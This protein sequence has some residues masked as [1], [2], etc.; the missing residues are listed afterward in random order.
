MFPAL[1]H[2]RLPRGDLMSL[3]TLLQ[4]RRIGTLVWASFFC[5]AFLLPGSSYGQGQMEET[6]L[7]GHVFNLRTGIPLKNAVVEVILFGPIRRDSDFRRFYRLTND[8]GFWEISLDPSDPT[9]YFV[10]LIPMC[11]T[12]KGLAP[13]HEQRVSLR[14][15]TM[16]RYLYVDAFRTRYASS[17][18][19]VIRTK[20]NKRQ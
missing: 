3:S 18:L 4:L 17:C 5:L 20:R 2:L 8:N 11:G 9:V 15:G 6:F 12:P 1:R 10:S 16:R 7:E 14:P 19:P 13:T